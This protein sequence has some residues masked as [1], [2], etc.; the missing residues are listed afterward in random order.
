[1]FGTQSAGVVPGPAV[2]GLEQQARRLEALAREVDASLSRLPRDDGV[3][4]GLA[5]SVYVVALN[6]LAGELTAARTQLEHAASGSRQAHADL[7]SRG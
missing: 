5:H 2:A 3:W 1:M 4:R 7:V 6:G